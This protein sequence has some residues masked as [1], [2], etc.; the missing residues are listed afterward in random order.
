MFCSF[1]SKQTDWGTKKEKCAREL[2]YKEIGPS[3]ENFEVSDVGFVI[4]PQWPHLGASPDG[5]VSCTCHGKG[6]IELKCPYSHKDD[7]IKNAVTKNNTFCLIEHD[8][9]LKLRR[10]H[11]CYYQIQTQMHICGVNYCDFVVCTVLTYLLKEY[12]KITV[13]GKIVLKLQLNVFH[14]VYYLNC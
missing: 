14:P 6:V 13:C 7:T 4:S 8:G 2:Y 12:S 11:T 1:S 5:V 3:H 9:K 10:D